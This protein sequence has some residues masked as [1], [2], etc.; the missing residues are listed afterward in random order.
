M[1]VMH[2]GRTYFSKNG[3][4][5]IV[6]KDPNWATMIG[7]RPGPGK[8]LSFGDLKLLNIM[9]KCAD[10]CGGKTC[11]NGGYL[12]KNCNCQCKGCSLQSCDGPGPFENLSCVCKDST[13]QAVYTSCAKRKAQGK[14][15]T[16][17][18][19]K[20]CPITCGYCS[21]DKGGSGSCRDLVTSCS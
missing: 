14:C 9:Y 21:I 4:P 1:G 20:Y 2:Y 8:A 17:W 11:P 6:T 15:G 13:N 3:K 16:Y 5:T 10:H 19:D 12:D 18:T 7:T